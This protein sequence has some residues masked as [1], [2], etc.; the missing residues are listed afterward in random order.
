MRCQPQELLDHP[1]QVAAVAVGHR[2]QSLTCLLRQRQAAATEL[3]GPL[4]ELGLGLVRQTVQHQ[5][6]AAGQESAVELEGGVLG[7][8]ADQ[9][10]R[11]VL[12]VGQEGVLLGAVEP[13]DLVNEEQSP[14]ADLTPLGSSTEDLAQ[15]GHP[16][17]GGGD[18]L[19][20]QAR[21]GGQQAGDGRLAASRRSPQDD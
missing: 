2:D 9:H 20:D 12:D 11:A 14:L 18:L 6:L 1:Q 3:L 19:E 15:L 21:A 17:E 13:V 10:H 8:G 4:D 16:R 7:G 5:H